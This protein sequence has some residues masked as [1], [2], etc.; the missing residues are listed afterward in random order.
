MK[1][2]NFEIYNYLNLTNHRLAKIY[3]LTG[4]SPLPESFSL[5]KEI[6]KERLYLSQMEDENV[7]PTF[8]S[9]NKNKIKKHFKK[10]LKN[11]KKTQKSYDFFKIYSKKFAEKMETYFVLRINLTEILLKNFKK[12]TF[13]EVKA[14][15]ELYNLDPVLGQFM[16]P[17]FEDKVNFDS[18]FADLEKKYNLSYSQ[19]M[20]L[21]EK[22]NN[23]LAKKDS[24]EIENNLNN[25]KRIKT[26]R[27]IIERNAKTAQKL[28]KNHEV[29][30]FR[31]EI[32]KNKAEIKEKR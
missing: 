24:V 23:D 30:K 17:L 8:V 32:K 21:I 11:C 28:K 27:K 31:E 5:S 13:D 16:N 9:E 14:Y 12:L 3:R 18:I 26:E 20:K 7:F 22:K 4:S 19:K 6:I 10:S 25:A 29:R 2:N 1:T 15:Q